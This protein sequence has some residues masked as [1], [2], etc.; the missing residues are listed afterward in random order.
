MPT[1]AAR[2]ASDK[3]V[4]IADLKHKDLL[5]FGR[6]RNKLCIP[7]PAAKVFMSHGHVALLFPGLL[8]A[9]YLLI[10]KGSNATERQRVALD[11]KSRH[12]SIRSQ[13]NEGV[14]PEFLPL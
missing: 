9:R 5:K 8:R 12:D 1:E 13:R 7:T 2:A 10:Q 3:D 14:V 4:L 11:A 6:R